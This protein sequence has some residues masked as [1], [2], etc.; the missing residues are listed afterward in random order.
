ME[1]SLVAD[2]IL[3]ALGLGF[4]PFV[5]LYHKM[6]MFELPG[7]A[8][9]S[10]PLLPWI[11]WRA[12]FA[13]SG[14]SVCSFWQA[15]AYGCRRALQ[16]KTGTWKIIRAWL[17]LLT[18]GYFLGG[19]QMRPYKCSYPILQCSSLPAPTS[20]TVHPP[21]TIRGHLTNIF[22]CLFLKNIKKGHK[23]YYSEVINEKVWT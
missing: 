19:N 2:R 4:L 21:A 5:S 22:S 13:G 17:L 15:S 16:S 18:P 12:T 3:W 6:M 11:S 8:K 20:Q 9:A 23:I 14:Q 10:A 7:I 1:I